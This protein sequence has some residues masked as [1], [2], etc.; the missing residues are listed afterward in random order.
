MDFE[1]GWGQ[2]GRYLERGVS[3]DW[4]WGLEEGKGKGRKGKRYE[5]P[6]DAWHL[7]WESGL[8]SLII[9]LAVG[10]P[11]LAQT[12]EALHSLPIL[13]LLAVLSHRVLNNF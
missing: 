3:W 10:A 1:M 7:P 11:K 12:S 6:S 4:N 9:V 8:P 5:V 13:Y 2:G